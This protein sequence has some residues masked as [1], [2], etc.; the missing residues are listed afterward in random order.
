MIKVRR[1]VKKSCFLFICVLVFVYIVKK[2]WGRC[3]GRYCEGGL[4][5]GKREEEAKFDIV[6]R[7]RGKNERFGKSEGNLMLEGKIDELLYEGDKYRK[8]FRFSE[9]FFIG[10]KFNKWISCFEK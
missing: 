9:K 10:L 5:I 3:K 1:R 6:W 4:R 8:R 7:R 2:K